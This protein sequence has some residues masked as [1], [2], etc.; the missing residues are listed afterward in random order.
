MRRERWLLEK[1]HCG[2]EGKQTMTA[3]GCLAGHRCPNSHRGATCCYAA[4]NTTPPHT[5]ERRYLLEF[6][7]RHPTRMGEL[8]CTLGEGEL[9]S[10]RW[11]PIA[12]QQATPVEMHY[13][14]NRT[15]SIARQGKVR[16]L[17]WLTPP[18]VHLLPWPTWVVCTAGQV[19]RLPSSL[20][21]RPGG[22]ILCPT[23]TTF[24]RLFLSPSLAWRM[25]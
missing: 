7:M 6:A 2:D 8:F 1:L 11:G 20:S 24:W 10:L 12:L 18:P 16:G 9:L 22:H 5:W 14:R 17:V 25:L 19:L 4:G 15:H 23:G 3:V 13:T 21:S